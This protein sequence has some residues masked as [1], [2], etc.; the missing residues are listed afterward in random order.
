MLCDRGWVARVMKAWRDLG[1]K[2]TSESQLMKWLQRVMETARPGWNPWEG[3]LCT[4]GP[5][6]SDSVLK[7]VD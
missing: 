4:G 7:I 1:F 3:S 2:R 5:W 6:R